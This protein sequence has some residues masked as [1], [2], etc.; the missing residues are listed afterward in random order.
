MKTYSINEE[1]RQEIL[2]YMWTRPYGEVY[3]LM[4]VVLKLEEN[5][6]ES[7]QKQETKKV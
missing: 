7:G 2:K 6:N 3:K 1:Q 4:E 5:K